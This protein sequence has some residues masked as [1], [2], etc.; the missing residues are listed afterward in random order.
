MHKAAHTVD[1]GSALRPIV[2]SP[3]QQAA[4]GYVVHPHLGH[5]VLGK[6]GWAGSRTGG[7]TVP[8]KPG[9]AGK[10]VSQTGETLKTRPPV[11][12]NLPP[13]TFPGRSLIAPSAG[14]LTSSPSSQ[15]YGQS[16][17]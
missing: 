5:S 6:A 1:L 15:P 2:G 3:D 10:L 4:P 14:A 13:G 7:A 16:A 17:A 8:Q 9:G 12:F 11:H